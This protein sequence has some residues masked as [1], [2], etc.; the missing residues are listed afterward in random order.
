MTPKNPASPPV[1]R[2]I[3]SSSQR[4]DVF[5]NPGW[6]AGC[7]HDSQSPDRTS[8]RI[9]LLRP[10]SRRADLLTSQKGG[11]G[12]F[13]RDISCPCGIFFG[14][15]SFPCPSLTPN[16][17]LAI[18]RVTGTPPTYPLSFLKKTPCPPPSPQN[19]QGFHG[20]LENLSFNP[21]FPQ[22]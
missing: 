12:R 6:V 1:A 21:V 9:D 17:P 16:K 22:I 7:F 8:V 11:S 14:R 3:P 18:R 15:R 13:P 4:V 10:P 20:P 2:S 19:V 5:W